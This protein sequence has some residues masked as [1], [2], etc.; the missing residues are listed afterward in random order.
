MTLK[1]K[2]IPFMT[3]K[4]E[5]IRDEIKSCKNILDSI[6]N[7]IIDLPIHNELYGELFYGI[8]KTAIIDDLGNMKVFSNYLFNGS[9]VNNYHNY[10]K[11]NKKSQIY[12][13]PKYMILRREYSLR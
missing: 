13:G 3:I 9:I 1:N 2:K 8:C 6:K 12:T 5:N 11:I 4:S 7:L 10:K